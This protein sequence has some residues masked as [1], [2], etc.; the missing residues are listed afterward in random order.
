KA[1]RRRR[2]ED[3]LAAAGHGA[4]PVI[5]PSLE[6]IGNAALGQVIGRHLDQH[7]VAR[8]NTDTILTHAAGGVG[9]DLVLVLKLHT[10]HGVGQEFGDDTGEL[11]KFFF[12]HRVSAGNEKVARNLTETT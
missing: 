9:N 3:K 2:G 11:Q 4:Y 12:G 6:A 5:G 8:E 10:K 7:A 1:A